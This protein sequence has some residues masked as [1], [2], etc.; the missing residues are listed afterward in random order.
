MVSS[1]STGGSTESLSRFERVELGTKEGDSQEAEGR[2]VIMQVFVDMMLR[3]L[4][5]VITLVPSMPLLLT[6]PW[7]LCAGPY[8]FHFYEVN[9]V[10]KD[11]ERV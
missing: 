3:Q 4:K 6:F 7:A 10:L 8:Y 11:K 2:P 5:F 9:T 1:N